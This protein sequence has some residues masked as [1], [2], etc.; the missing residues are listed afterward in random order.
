[1]V[2]DA[3]SLSNRFGNSSMSKMVALSQATVSFLVQSRIQ[4]RQQYFI[5]HLVKM[6]G[7]SSKEN[8]VAHSPATVSFWSLSRIQNRHDISPSSTPNVRDFFL[9]KN[10][11]S[12]DYLKLDKTLLNHHPYWSSSPGM[13]WGAVTKSNSASFPTWKCW[14][15]IFAFSFNYALLPPF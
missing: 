11:R 13:L 12:Q 9:G 3:K 5:L 6:F 8:V 2:V 15:F 14:Q 1:M 4:N 10:V 7:I